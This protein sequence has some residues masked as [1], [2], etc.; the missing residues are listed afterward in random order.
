[1]LADVGRAALT[2]PLRIEK[3]DAG[4]ARESDNQSGEFPKSAASTLWIVQEIGTIAGPFDGGAQLVDIR[5]SR[6]AGDGRNF[7]RIV[8]LD[9]SDASNL[10]RRVFDDMLAAMTMHA[11]DMK[12]EFG[13]AHGRNISANRHAMG[14][15]SHAHSSGERG[16]NAKA[17]ASEASGADLVC[18]ADARAER[19]NYERIAGGA[20]E[21]QLLAQPR[22]E[23][24]ASLWRVTARSC[25][26][27]IKHGS[28]PTAPAE[29]RPGMLA[30]QHRQQGE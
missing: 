26:V 3:N 1:M 14:R 8:R 5:R 2:D 18:E 22:G 21:D 20:R 17:R 11:V 27:Q 15:R 30:L 16:A 10:R 28:P 9:R 23:E 12:D 13:L 24:M 19:E 7:A 29:D 25:A 6:I 4:D